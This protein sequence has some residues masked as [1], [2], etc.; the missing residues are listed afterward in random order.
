METVPHPQ[1][2]RKRSRSGK[3]RA[4]HKAYFAR[5]MEN[6]L[7]RLGA[8]YRADPVPPAQAVRDLGAG[9]KVRRAQAVEGR[10]VAWDTPITPQRQEEP[11][12]HRPGK[13]AGEIT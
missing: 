6:L 8:S 2:K 11:G 4:R 12:S 1:T 10:S 13:K 9:L 3:T 7:G 5:E